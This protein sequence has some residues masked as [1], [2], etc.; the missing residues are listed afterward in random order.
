MN[1]QAAAKA[2]H[3]WRWAAS[4]RHRLLAATVAALVLALALAGV[5][6]SGLFRDHVTRQFE[7]SLTLQLDQLTARL[8]FDAQGQ[9]LIDTQALSDP[10]WQTPYSGLYWQIDRMSAS[11]Q[12][13]SGVLRSRS[14]WDTQ[15]TLQADTLNTGSLHV[16]HGV[17]PKGAEVLMVERTVRSDESPGVGWRLIVAGDLEQTMAAATRF[18]RLLALALLALGVMLAVAAWAQVAV[19][20]APLRA[21]Q[22]ALSD[23]REGREARLQ[24]RFPVEVQPLIDDFNGVL[25]RNADVVQRARSHAGNLAHALKTPLA[26]LIQA[27]EQASHSNAKADELPQ[28]VQEQVTLARRHI[29]WHLARSRMAAAQRLPGLRTPLAPVVKGLLRVMQRVNAER[30]LALQA[31]PIPEAWAFGGEAQ[32]LQE[33]LGNLLD[34]ACKWARSAVHVSATRSNGQLVLVIEDD[35]PGIAQAQRETALARGERLD[36]RTPGSGLG[37]AI[38]ADL[39]Q[40]YGGTLSLEAS[41]MG[42]L[43]VRLSLPATA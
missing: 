8:E 11:G 24:G 31:T 27:A 38:V 18:N 42:G 1:P 9:P 12:S 14:L 22:G 36:E 4:L 29:D 23:V 6:L 40:L 26:V 2:R 20:L 19:G 25:D 21:L 7:A 37:L 17:G 13:R 15:L 10:R 16:H 41:P 43:L 34:N 30:E 5:F 32:D 28:L 35:G 33:M 3:E 39:V